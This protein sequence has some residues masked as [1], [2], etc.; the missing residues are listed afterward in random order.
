MFVTWEL[1]SLNLLSFIREI[2]KSEINVLQKPI[3]HFFSTFLSNLLFCNIDTT[4]IIIITTFCM[5]PSFK[6]IL[7]S[8]VIPTGQLILNML[9]WQRRITEQTRTKHFF[10]TH[11]IDQELPSYQQAFEASSAWVPQSVHAWKVEV[12]RCESTYYMF[13][14]ISSLQMHIV[15]CKPHKCKSFLLLTHKQKILRMYTDMTG[16]IQITHKIGPNNS[17]E[18]AI[19]KHI[20]DTSQ[21]SKF[22]YQHYFHIA[23]TESNYNI[24]S[25]PTKPRAA[26]FD[27]CFYTSYLQHLVEGWIMNSINIEKITSEVLSLHWKDTLK[28]MY[29]HWL[30]HHQTVFNCI[31]WCK[32]S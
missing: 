11:V 16:L 2:S 12:T 31:L 14:C 23:S 19:V 8:A 21:T 30:T 22:V 27:I 5:P 10:Q 29:Q 24:G 13:I 15:F 1:Q 20:H 17:L 28:C 4:N 6:H 26:I 3:I 32:S 25:I 7:R 18:D 9:Q